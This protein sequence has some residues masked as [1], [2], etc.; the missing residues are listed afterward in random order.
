MKSNFTQFLVIA[1]LGGAVAILGLQELAPSLPWKGEKAANATAKPDLVRDFHGDMGI[2]RASFSPDAIEELL[3]GKGE[4]S[5]ADR[6]KLNELISKI[7]PKQKPE[8]PER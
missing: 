1:L 2:E 8:N 6:R 7:I 4:E 5:R 3:R